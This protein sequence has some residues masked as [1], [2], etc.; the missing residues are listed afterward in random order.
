M[1]LQYFP[2][3]N[4][5]NLYRKDF[6]Y[7][8]TFLLILFSFP[9][10]L[11]YF[12]HFQPR[13]IF[14]I[15]PNYQN[16]KRE[17]CDY[18]KG[19]WVPDEGTDLPGSYNESCQFLD[20]GFRCHRNGRKDDGYL[21]WRWQP[22]NCSIPRFNAT[23]FLERSKNGRI[24][25]AGDSIGRNQWESLVCMLSQAISNHTS[26]YEES[27]KPITKHKGY[28]S[29]RFND[30]NLTVEY[31]RVPFLVIVDRPP[32]N[33]SNQI[34]STV[35]VDQ[36]HWRS[37]QWNGANILIF[38][39][40]HW[41]S[42]DKTIKMGCYFQE[43]GKINIT[44]NVQEAFWKSLQTWRSW[45]TQ[46]THPDNSYIFFRSY[47]PTHY[48]QN[49]LTC[50]DFEPYYCRGGKWDEGGHC[51]S[52]TSPEN[53]YTKLKTE[54]WNNMFIYKTIEMMKD[55][56]RNI[57]FLNIT[58][59]TEYRKDGHPSVHREPGTPIPSPQDCSHW[60]LPGVPDTWNKLLYA[61]LLSKDYRSKK[62][63]NL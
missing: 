55:M 43:G 25:F 21:K 30:Y 26:I 52:S 5:H 38:N 63:K 9:L 28:L 39:A 35:R 29:I 41:W 62:R 49:T 58:Y 61:H 8:L 2:V 37:K 42:E 32:H 51:D 16:L 1:D 10:F 3:R 12:D 54:P 45:V 15:L 33:S 46:N 48:R 24:V 19:K 14:Q 47:S 18:S 31:Y 59:L 36:L 50:Y 20:P 60:C 57:Q 6:L 7:T 22:E 27:G 56:K 4:I 17:T 11:G 44:M 34:Q 13:F 23:D 53:N 40:G